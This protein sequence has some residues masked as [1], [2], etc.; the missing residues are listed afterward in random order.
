MVNELYEGLAAR[1]GGRFA[2]AATGITGGGKTTFLRA[3]AQDASLSA[4]YSEEEGSVSAQVALA[5]GEL[6]LEVFESSY[7]QVSPRSASAA[8]LVTS[9][10]SFGRTRSECIAEEEEAAR[11]LK[12]SA[13]PFV[14]LVNTADPAS[15]ACETLRKS[16]EEKYGVLAFA[17]NCAGT[18]DCAALWEGILFSFPAAGLE[19]RL[20]EWMSVLPEESKIIADIM[21]KVREIA[22]KICRVKDCSLLETAFA[23]GDVYCES[24]ETDVNSGVA[25]YSI[26]AQDGMFYKVLSEECGADITDDLRLMAYVRSLREAKRFYGKFQGALRAADELGYGI[27]IPSEEDLALQPPELVRRGVK[28]GV[29]LKADACS[30]HII[31]VDVHGEVF[32]VTGDAARSEEIAKGI[33]DSYEKD[34]EALWNTDMFGKSFKD[35]IRENLNEKT[36]PEEAR[37]KLRKAVT[38][39]VN[40]GKGGVLCILL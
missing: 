8:V 30:Y 21:A 25:R 27:V 20:P 32:P 4:K 22:P 24:C 17:A 6:Q 3:V 35:M 31:K 40:E 1:T 14:V 38:R 7:E 15:D 2:L 9:D 10:G 11:A 18:V 36:M 29:K 23:E 19:I 16:L 26:A 39:I 13:V 33:V 12:E 5:A 34:P 28:C 37:G